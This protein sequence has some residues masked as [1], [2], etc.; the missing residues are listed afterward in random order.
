MTYHDDYNLNCVRY[1][2]NIIYFTLYM[3][4]KQHCCPH[5]K[6]A[7]CASA[8][9]YPPQIPPLPIVTILCINTVFQY[10]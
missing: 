8:P 2:Y 4:A 3:G 7:M 10:K 9:T 1:L 5:K 6:I